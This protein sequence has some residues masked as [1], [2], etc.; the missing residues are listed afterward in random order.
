MTI[1]LRG[2]PIVI[3]GASSG[4]GAA[5]A[6]ACARAGMPLMLAARR[7]DRLHAIADRARRLGVDADLFALDVA[8]EP[9]CRELIDR[10]WRRFGRVHAVFAN[11]GFA[12]EA[13]LT[14]AMPD[15]A[16]RETFETNFFGS[17]N[18]LRPAIERQLAESWSPGS[19]IRGHMLMCSSCLARLGAPAYA[20]YSA[21]KA[22]QD[23]FAR[24]MRVEL[25]DRG[26]RVSGVHP[27]GKRP[28]FFD[29]VAD[30]GGRLVG[31]P[32]GRFMQ[33]PERVASAV[34]RCL[35]RP[36]G[37]VW[38]SHPVRI[39]LALTGLVPGLTDRAL[40]RAYR[41]RAQHPP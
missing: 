4:I 37:E 5:T 9:R 14:H 27:I 11:A 7:A 18:V 12:E 19:P 26:I 13:P 15:R 35:R 23:H 3:T 1:D 31:R 24:A 22:M 21:S 30:R 6:L 36:R 8:D 28:E 29:K 25:W 32:P 40:V 34:L 17:L 33:P 20:A 16:V 41:R 2:R 38:T 39:V 10:A